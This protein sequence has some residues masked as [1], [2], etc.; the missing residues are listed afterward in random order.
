[1]NHAVFVL[2]KRGGE[3]M[4]LRMGRG[5]WA[6]HLNGVVYLLDPGVCYTSSCII[7]WSLSSSSIVFKGFT[8]LG[9]VEGE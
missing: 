2:R 6:C 4:R 8:M 7:P 3:V 5:R 1:M 9:V